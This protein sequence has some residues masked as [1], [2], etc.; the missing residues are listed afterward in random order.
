MLIGLK[1]S[2][3]ASKRRGPWKMKRI[4]PADGSRPSEGGILS[5]LRVGVEAL[6]RVPSEE[7]SYLPPLRYCLVGFHH[8]GELWGKSWQ[9]DPA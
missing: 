7:T 8:A 3:K 4:W 6:S 9:R 2:G 1:R 5:R